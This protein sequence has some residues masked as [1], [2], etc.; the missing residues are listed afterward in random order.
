MCLT[1]SLSVKKAEELPNAAD[2]DGKGVA[3]AS[4]PDSST[5]RYLALKIFDSNYVCITVCLQNVLLHCSTWG[6][7]VTLREDQGEEEAF[8]LLHHMLPCM[9]WSMLPPKLSCNFALADLGVQ[10]EAI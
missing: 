3:F 8:N 4:Y 5:P 7:S 10:E 9:S 2:I 6:R 1:C